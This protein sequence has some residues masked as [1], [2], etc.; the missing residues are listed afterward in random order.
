M[1]GLPSSVAP[2]LRLQDDSSCQACDNVRGNCTP[3][4]L[5]QCHSAIGAPIAG[6]QYGVLFYFMRRASIGLFVGVS[7]LLISRD[8][9][10]G[11]IFAQCLGDGLHS[12]LKQKF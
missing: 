11:Y 10:S 9:T 2:R 1:L 8:R 6:T 7:V 3:L 5:V 4:R 12:L